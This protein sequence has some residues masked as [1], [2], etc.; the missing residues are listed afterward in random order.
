MYHPQKLL[1][2]ATNWVGDAVMSLPALRLV[3]ARFPGAH[4]SVLARP[5]VADLY[6][7]ESWL[8]E[9]IP[10]TPAPGRTDLTAKWR[11]ARSLA[12]NHFD[13]ALLLPNSFES[14][15]IAFLA[16]IPN[17]IGYSRDGRGTLLTRALAV[18][19]PGEIPAHETFYYLELI[20][21]TGWLDA[22]PSEAPPYLEGV[23]EA[24]HAG[25]ALLASQGLAGDV[26]GLSPGAAFGTAK[27]W[28]PERFAAAAIE[29]A[30][31]RD[32][33]VALF[34]S[35]TERALCEQIRSALA[36]HVRAV[37]NFAGETSLRQF[38]DA[39]AACRLFLT[40]D[41]GAMHIAYATG[42]P[43]VTVFGPTD[44][45]GTGPVGDHTRIVRHPVECSPCKLREC[46]I[47]HR[48]MKGVEAG[49]VALTALELL[50]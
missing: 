32:M 10:Y 22:L 45:I 5:W 37:H 43:T 39:A 30:T 47:D 27:R 34:G 38:I 23:D 6:G 14:A 12:H 42:V 8:N 26:L 9:V 2:R 11:A 19:K 46:P 31:A 36:G 18:P 13:T 48:C 1:I 15:A 49:R 25:G 17:R 28:Y 33:C 21:R 7:R 44:H 16:R 20:R 40:N 41:S 24:R 35:T 50:K 29:T 4:I 3:R